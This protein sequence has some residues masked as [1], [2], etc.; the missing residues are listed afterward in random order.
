MLVNQGR[1]G[2]PSNSVCQMLTIH[3]CQFFDDAPL[4]RTLKHIQTAT[5][6]LRHLHIRA[7]SSYAKVRA[8]SCARARTGHRCACS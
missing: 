8:L 1:E 2:V 7:F 5:H 6:Q 3:A 4:R